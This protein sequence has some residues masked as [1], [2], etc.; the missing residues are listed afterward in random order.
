MLRR[1]WLSNYVV[2]LSFSIKNSPRVV[3][4]PSSLKTINFIGLV[5][6]F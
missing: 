3:V 6:E 5:D 4:L 1:A 2:Y